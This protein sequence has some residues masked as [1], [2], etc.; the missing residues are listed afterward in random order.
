[1]FSSFCKSAWLGAVMSAVMGVL[2]LPC[3]AADVGGWYADQQ[4]AAAMAA[5]KAL[6]DGCPQLIEIGRAHV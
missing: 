3:H 4:K 1:M 2:A 6:D 5:T